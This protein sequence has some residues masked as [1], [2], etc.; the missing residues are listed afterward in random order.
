MAVLAPNALFSDL[1]ARVGVET[2]RPDL[3]N[4]RIA[5][6]LLAATMA[7]HS[8][9]FFYKD[10]LTADAQFD[11]PPGATPAYLQTLD[12]SVLPRFRALAYVRKWDPSYDVTQLNPTLMPPLWNNSLGIPINP[13]LALGFLKR[14]TPDDIL[15]NYGTE[16][17]DVYYAAGS[18]LFMKSSTPLVQAKLGWYAHPR[19][20]VENGFAYYESWLASEFPMAVVYYAAANVFTAIGM[21]DSANNLTRRPD[22]KVPGDT[23]GPLLGQIN[24]ILTSN[25]IAEG[26]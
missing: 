16:K 24:A 4:T 6:A 1:Q 12:T 3:A 10:I 21:N 7:L 22:P 5:Q 19:T 13:N 20:D 8:L 2:S 26:Y 17:F 14:I 11:T 25:I 9:D 23:G 18:T 15:D